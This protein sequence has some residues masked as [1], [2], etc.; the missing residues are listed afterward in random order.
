MGIDK[1]NLDFTI[2]EFNKS[3]SKNSFEYKFSRNKD[4]IK[5]KGLVINK[6]NWAKKINKP[7]Y[8]ITPVVAGITFTYGGIKVNSDFNVILNDDT[9]VS[10][11]FACGEIVGGV[12]YQ[13]YAGGT[14]LM[15]GSVS[16]KIAGENS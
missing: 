11:V 12:H 8:Y 14:G 9:V 2:S 16:G 4:H 10:N 7:P 6:S 15:F 1:K 13:N 3:I 5:T